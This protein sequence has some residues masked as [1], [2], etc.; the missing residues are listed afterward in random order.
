[1]RARG[2][3]PGQGARGQS[4]TPEP[5]EHRGHSAHGSKS[6]RQRSSLSRVRL[7]VTLGTVAHQAAVFMEFS[8]Q[9]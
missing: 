7:C 3:S 6:E 8:R 2:A 9:G 5:F 4:E 1:M